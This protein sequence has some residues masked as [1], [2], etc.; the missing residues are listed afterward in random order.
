MSTTC[1]PEP[2]IIESHVM[3]RNILK[4]EN[5]E[6]AK[7]ARDNGY[8]LVIYSGVDCVYGEPEYLIADPKQLDVIAVTRKIKHE[9]YEDPDDC[10]MTVVYKFERENIEKETVNLKEKKSHKKKRPKF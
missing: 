3:A 10:S 4:T 5:R 1:I 8:D 7:N 6:E 2:K 9:Y